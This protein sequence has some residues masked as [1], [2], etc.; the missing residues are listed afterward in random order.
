MKRP[1]YLPARGEAWEKAR[2]RALVRDDFTCQAHQL[3]LCESCDESR[4][5]HLVVHHKIHRIH[6]GT[7]DLDNLLTL[8]NKHHADIHPH[9]R[10]ELAEKEKVIEMNG[11]REL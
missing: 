8:C 10:A 9:L 2:M 1:H 3:G 11:M 5:R 6:G 7:H 4:L